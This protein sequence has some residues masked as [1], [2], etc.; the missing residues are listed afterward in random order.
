[1]SGIL[2][3]FGMLTRNI[4]GGPKRSGLVDECMN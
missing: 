1:M 2:G 3:W 4:S